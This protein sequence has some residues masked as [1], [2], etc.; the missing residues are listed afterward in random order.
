MVT[1]SQN[2]MFAVDSYFVRVSNS[3]SSLKLTIWNDQ[4]TKLLSEFVSLD[5][6]EAFWN[7]IAAH[8]SEAVAQETKKRLYT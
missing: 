1:V 7:L 3:G 5:R 2:M 6:S 8:T 4:G